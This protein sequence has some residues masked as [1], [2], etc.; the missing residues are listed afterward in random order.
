[1]RS[2]CLINHL[3]LISKWP[4]KKE[5]KGSE[6]SYYH[7]LSSHSPLIAFKFPPNSPWNHST[8]FIYFV[9]LC[10]FTVSYISF[11]HIALLASVFCNK[12]YC[13]LFWPF[14]LFTLTGSM[15]FCQEGHF[16]LFFYLGKVSDDYGV[17]VTWKLTVSY[18]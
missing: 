5:R 11:R 14:H 3:S 8:I 18:N 17:A 16:F 1:M 15:I 4:F 13:T 6:D 9:C 7:P 2:T 10:D 12:F